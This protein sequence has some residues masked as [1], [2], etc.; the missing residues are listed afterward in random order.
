MDRNPVDITR[1][2]LGAREYAVIGV[3][4]AGFVAAV[5]AA[6]AGWLN[7]QLFLIVIA[8][9]YML[10]DVLRRRWKKG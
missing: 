2:Q 5:G 1:R 4:C 8:A 3:F 6:L 10:F 7:A 9:Q